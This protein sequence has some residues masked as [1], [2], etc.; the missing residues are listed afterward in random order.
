MTGS[1]LL[2]ARLRRCRDWSRKQAEPIG[3]Q[4]LILW[5]KWPVTE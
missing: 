2:P 5:A 1:E 4:V 3:Q